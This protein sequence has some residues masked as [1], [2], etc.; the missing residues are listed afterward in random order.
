LAEDSTVL[1][2]GVAAAGADTIFLNLHRALDTFEIERVIVLFP[3]LQRR[4]LRFGVEG[5]HFRMPVTNGNV[6]IDAQDTCIWFQWAWLND[7]ISQVRRDLCMDDGTAE[8]SRRVIGRTVKL[9]QRKGVPFWVSS[10][11]TETYEV[12]GSVVSADHLL[13]FFRKDSDALDGVHSSGQSHRAW[14]EQIVPI[15]QS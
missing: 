4:L 10:W 6:I 2:L 3:N 12:L 9:L 7:R 8:Y 11:D 15:I 5:Q 1:N 14:L 13:P